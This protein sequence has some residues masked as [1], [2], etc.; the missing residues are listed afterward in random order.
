MWFA[1]DTRGTRAYTDWAG[2]PMLLADAC[3]MF[4]SFGLRMA[5]HKQVDDAGS[6]HC[7][8]FGVLTVGPESAGSTPGRSR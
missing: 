5:A 6:V 7:F 1:T 8:E 4:E 2:Q 3:A